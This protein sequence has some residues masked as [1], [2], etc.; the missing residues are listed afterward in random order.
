MRHQNHEITQ[1]EWIT[2]RNYIFIHMA[3]LAFGM[4]KLEAAEKL[5]K[6]AMR[7]YLEAG[8]EKDD[9][10]L[11]EISMK[12]AMLYAMQEKH[13]EAVEGYKFAIEAQERKMSQSEVIDENTIAL[14]GMCLDAFSKY[15]L[16]RNN[17][18]DAYG[19]TERA[20]TVAFQ[21]FGE[22]HPQTATLW[23]DLANISYLMGNI[24][25]AISQC[26]KAIELGELLQIPELA[27]FYCNLGS[28]LLHNGEFE[29]AFEKCTK[30]SKLAH[31]RESRKQARGCLKD[32]KAKKSS[33]NTEI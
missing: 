4:F 14:W 10:A 32:I 20:L 16:T 19:Y 26:E 5:F 28:I 3:N 13:E 2:K 27:A 12:L 22:N 18:R 9:N 17:Y 33:G 15:F 6:D 29:K 1:D 21:V 30:A 11:V 23:N 24:D 7:G 31:D 25:N 8:L